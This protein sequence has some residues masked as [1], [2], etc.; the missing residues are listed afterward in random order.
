[1]AL[2]EVQMDIVWWFCKHIWSWKKLI[3]RIERMRRCKL[4]CKLFRSLMTISSLAAFARVFPLRITVFIKTITL[5]EVSFGVSPHSPDVIFCELGWCGCLSFATGHGLIPTR[6][7]GTVTGVITV[8]SS[9][10]CCGH[11]PSYHQCSE[12]F[13]RGSSTCKLSVLTA[14]D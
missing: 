10:R 8:L 7:L 13:T 2:W 3:P 6:F 14:H 12:L 4:P 11:C 5:G 9:Y 1:M